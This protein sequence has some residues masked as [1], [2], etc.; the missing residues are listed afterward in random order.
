MLK[1]YALSLLVS[2]FAFRCQSQDELDL[3]IQYLPQTKYHETIERRSNTETSYTGSDDVML[4]LRNKGVDNPSVT[5][6][7]FKMESVLKTDSL[8]KG[9]TFPLTIEIIEE[10]R[11]DGQSITPS[12]TIVY[13]HSWPGRMPVLDS[14]YSH[15]EES[16]FKGEILRSL[17]RTFSEIA[18]PEKE[19]RVG[20]EFKTEAPFFRKIDG[21]II[22]FS[23]I[24]NYRLES[25]DDDIADFD[26]SVEYSLKTEPMQYS[27]NSTGSGKGEMKYDIKENFCELF[28]VDQELELKLQMTNY[29][30][31]TKTTDFFSRS[32]E[33]TKE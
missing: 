18:L 25:I 19:L 13:G 6:L 28:E 24:S 2:A 9:D 22:E 7:H 26:I 8:I 30:V 29:E 20:E 1:L 5:G 21:I 11:D 4:K 33:I 23:L 12:G 16:S 27:I 32:T 3:K 10:S 15:G 31:E 17:N 14:I